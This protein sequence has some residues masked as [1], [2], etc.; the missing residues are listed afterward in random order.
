MYISRSMT[1]VVGSNS[2]SFEFPPA[3]QG[4][5]HHHPTIAFTALAGNAFVL[6][7]KNLGLIA[8]QKDSPVKAGETVYLPLP[9]GA[10]INHFACVSADQSPAVIAVSIGRK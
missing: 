9:E 10:G 8:T 4:H 7:G 2:Q 5:Y 1:A 3:K 6:V